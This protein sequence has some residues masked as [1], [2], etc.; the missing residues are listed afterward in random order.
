[1]KNI[2]LL[3]FFLTITTIISAQ[4]FYSV[5]ELEKKGFEKKLAISK[6]SYPGDAE[7]DVTYYKLDLKVTYS[8]NYL[9]GIV[10]VNAKPASS[11][12]NNFF[13]DLQNS[14]T[15]DSIKLGNSKLT[16]TH[17]NAKINITLDRTYST[18]EEFSIAVYYQ[19]TPGSS[20]FGSFE[21]GTQ[22]GTPKGEPVI[23]SL[24]EPYGASDW[25]PCKDTPADKADSSDVWI[26][27]SNQYTGVSN[28]TLISSSINADDTRTF[29]WKNTY[30]IAQYLISIAV[31]NY[32]LYT[33]YFYY[34]QNGKPDSM[35]ITHYLYPGKLSSIKAQIDETP[36]MIKVFSEKYGL[37]PFIKEKYG[38]A[39][40]GWGGS[41]EHQTC[42]SMGP[43]TFRRDVISHELAHQWFGDKVT[44]KTWQDIWLNEG[45]AEYSEAVYLEAIGGKTSYI[46]Q[47]AGEMNN[48]K[49][50]VGPVYVQD[51]SSVGEIFNN[52][53]T[54][55]KGACVL[56]MLRSVVGD[57][58]FFNILRTYDSDP[59]LAYNSATTEDFQSV[60]ESV[61]GMDLNYFF[62]EWIY[63]EN[64]P[65]Y[66]YSWS[67]NPVSSN[68]YE[69][70]LN[71]SQSTNSNPIFFTMP[72]Q[73]KITTTSGDTLLTV[74]NNQQQQQFNINLTSQPTDL[75]FDPDNWILKDTS[76]ATFVNDKFN[77]E[78]FK[79]EQNY[80]NPF[81]PTT[82]IKYSITAPNTK[83]QANLPKGEAL[84][85]L[86]IYD[87]LGN[88]VAT[89]VNKQ[90]QPG[91]YEV[92]LNAAKYHLSS[93]IYLYQ[94][95]T[96]GFVVA[97]KLVLLK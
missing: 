96:N 54:Y 9:I 25:W 58:T 19:G 34:S 33:N 72:I 43:N 84:V 21:F 24:S 18:N 85:Q 70:T 13:L 97:K 30:P 22:D 3:M 20:G 94:L 83:W 45:F 48:A 10:Q 2:L 53:R 68:N 38:H 41:M 27:C 82:K 4:E 7:I 12:L 64:Y 60:A 56:H 91:D 87:I 44:C 80:P 51:I 92:T 74:M 95:K 76:F 26:T 50:A 39:E 88:E 42:T 36:N 31:T 79:L 73:I 69:V 5:A 35:P 37:Y 63:G 11:S 77:I 17:Q 49:N 78:T 81:N 46:N 14:L 1:M 59:Q 6:V 90:Q 57:S 16:F 23:W 47:I 67:S 52:S 29:K 8:P 71:I 89:L 15:V 66:S 40:F 62:S 28:G 65:K 75:S 86:K 93:G 61:S 32:E 55:A